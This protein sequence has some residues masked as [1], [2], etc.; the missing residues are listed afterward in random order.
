M[1]EF[2]ED[3]WKLMTLCLLTTVVALLLVLSIHL[4]QDVKYWQ[5]LEQITEQKRSARI[6]WE[7]YGEKVRASAGKDSR[8]RAAH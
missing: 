5:H 8:P 7:E 3:S 1:V 2:R 6:S 4:H